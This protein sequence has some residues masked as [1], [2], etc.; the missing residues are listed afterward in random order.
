MHWRNHSAN[1]S[2]ATT[3]QMRAAQPQ[4]QCTGATTAQ[5]RAAQ[6]Q[7]YYTGATVVVSAGFEEVEEAG[8][9]FVDHGEEGGEFVVDEDGHGGVGGGGADC[10]GW[11]TGS[12]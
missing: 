8:A 2:G 1:A 9:A 4:S 11:T 6:P 3:A 12:A 7:S 5:M 10:R